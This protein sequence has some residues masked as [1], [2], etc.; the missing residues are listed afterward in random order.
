MIRLRG[1]GT[2]RVPATSV[3]VLT[4]MLVEI[5]CTSSYPSQPSGSGSTPSPRSSFAV[6]HTFA[7]EIVLA[8]RK[9]RHVIFLVKE[10]RTFDTLF[11]RFPGADGTTTG[12]LCNGKT[13]RLPHAHD[14]SMGPSHSFTDAIMAIDGGKMDCF[15]RIYDGRALQ[16]YVQ[17]RGD[18][19]PNYWS[20]ARHFTLADHFFSSIYGPTLVEHLD[21]VA[22]S[23]GRFVDNERPPQ[24]GSG[25]PGEYC[26]DRAERLTSFPKLSVA[27][28]RQAYQL[29]QQAKITALQRD[30][31]IQR[32]PCVNLRV[33]PDELRRAGVKWKYYMS[34]EPFFDVMRMIR[35]VR[36]GPMWQRVVPES[37]FLPDLQGGR[38]PAVSWLLP[39]IQYSDHPAYGSLC[40]GE[41]WTVSILNAIMRTRYWRHSIVVLTWDDFGGFYDHV[42]PPHEDLYGFGPRVPTI[43]ISRWARRG[44]IDHQAM[45]FDSVLRLI[46]TI[47]RVPALTH[48]DATANN[49]LSAFDFDRKPMPP[50]ILKQR[51]CS[52]AT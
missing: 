27:G 31:F 11:G 6:P 5:S 49:M 16:G 21:I 7:H 47:F 19:I 3:V 29:E 51:N 40:A 36:Y 28:R 50:F 2:R 43:V 25:G 17:Y 10:N 30:F 24:W 39:P 33:L 26:D 12:K 9:I 32:W 14:D 18:Q 41:N 38:L 44:F 42:P 4:L 46:E 23:T 1:G 37:T 34:P 8:R 48:R 35:H 22:A 52:L 20:Y 13:V 45:S 15:N